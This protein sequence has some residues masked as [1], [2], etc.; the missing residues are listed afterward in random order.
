MI[1]NH[2]QALAV[3]IE[4]AL[5]SCMDE[6]DSGRWR[7]ELNEGEERSLKEALDKATER[8]PEVV[9][10]ALTALKGF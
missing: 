9:E 7:Y 4:N 2:D 8:L 3:R 1:A 5:G 6:G 10:I